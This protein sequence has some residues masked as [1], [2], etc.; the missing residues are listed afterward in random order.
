MSSVGGS[1]PGFRQSRSRSRAESASKPWRI[2]AVFGLLAIVVWGL[3]SVNVIPLA[4]EIREGEVS[5]TNIRSPRKLT[6]TSQVRT[7]AEREQAA[8]AVQ[9][10]VEI[11]PAAVQ[12]QRAGLNALL[13]NVSAART[14]HSSR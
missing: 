14:S 10:V 11:D 9:E 12:R 3:L 6:Y 7:K 13:Q 5:Q 2:V 1:S 4:I 8:S